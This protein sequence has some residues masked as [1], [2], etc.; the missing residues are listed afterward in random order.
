MDRA[1]KVKAWANYI[2][3]QEWVFED[4]ASIGKAN[5][6]HDLLTSIP[7]FNSGELANRLSR[8]ILPLGFHFLYNNSSNIHLGADG[9]DNYQAPI[10]MQNGSEL[11]SRRMWVGGNVTFFGHP[12]ALNSSLTCKELVKS[13]RHLGASAFVS[14]DRSFYD[15]HSCLL[16]RENRNLV[17]TNTRHK[18]KSSTLENAFSSLCDIEDEKRVTLS[19]SMEQ[20]MKYSF[21]TYNMHK[22]HYD[23]QYC[24]AQEHLPNILVQ[25]PFMVTLLLYWFNLNNTAPGALSFSYKNPEPC[26]ENDCLTLSFAKRDNRDYRMGIFN[27]NN[28]KRFLVGSL[29]LN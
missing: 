19:L 3:S 16:L 6:L 11:F 15:K 12:I 5:N 23:R 21:L 29:K 9:Y 20:I 24:A 26:F 18:P 22:I 4:T 27:A 7:C 1:S 28:T 10:D 25:G 14:I 13:V 17:Y 8:N 2:K